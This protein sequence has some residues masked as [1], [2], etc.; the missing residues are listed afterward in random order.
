MKLRYYLILA[1]A[2]LSLASCREKKEPENVRGEKYY[3]N[4]FACSMMSTYYLWAD[5]IDAALDS[6]RF[7]DDPVQKVKEARY[8]DSS[9][10][11]IDKWTQ[12]L[13]SYSE[14]IES[15]SGQVTSYGYDFLFYRQRANSDDLCAVVSLCYPDTPAAEAS[16]K[17]GDVIM[18]INGKTI[19]TAN[20]QSLYYSDFMG[21]S[22]CTL[23]LL[24]GRTVTLKARQIYENPV[25]ERRVFDCGSKKVGYLLYTSFTLESC[26][27]LIDAF[28]FFKSEGVKE[29]VLDLRYNGG[30]YV[31]TENLIA[32]MLAPAEAVE[33]EELYML[34]VY[35]SLLTDAWGTS[36]THFT[37]EFTGTMSGKQYSFSTSGCN[38]DIDKLYVLV[39]NN[40]ASASESIITGLLPFI[41]VEII[42][43]QTSGKYCA[44]IMESAE[45]WYKE[46]R[47]PL[48]ENEVD[49]DEALSFC[50][51][52][53][54]YVMIS[55]YADKNGNTPC[56]PDGFIPDTQAD[57]T[58][59]DGIA[60][61]DPSEH[62][63]SIALAKA[64]YQAPVKAKTSQAGR[65]LQM[66]DDQP[67]RQ[68]YRLFLPGDLRPL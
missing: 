39:T 40:S 56:M 32:S 11:D 8:K 64:G 20:Y 5:E 17:R 16:I 60:L 30:G 23:S 2:L 22:E 50:G 52:W 38:L 19:T 15:M 21:G 36:E 3:I 68:T 54:I 47:K 9:G 18:K 42:G 55:R 61:G 33:K 37:T 48:E 62:M 28:K 44:G 10:K 51:D 4:T 29:L 59:E 57:D 34:D 1:L 45:A 12:A 66:L 7:S 53:G 41:D 65:S 24:D 63:L 49:V 25:L 6:W 35:N 46:T 27:D 58:P 67:G 43:T 26:N 31:L 14:M 13:E